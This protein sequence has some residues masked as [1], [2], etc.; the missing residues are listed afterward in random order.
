MTLPRQGC[1]QQPPQAQGSEAS[2]AAPQCHKP[3]PRPRPRPAPHPL[4]DGVLVRRHARPDLGRRDRG[5]IVRVV[6]VLVQVLDGFFRE[7][8]VQVGC[9]FPWGWSWLRGRGQQGSPR[10]RQVI[11]QRCPSLPSFRPPGTVASGSLESKLS[12]DLPGP[13]VAS[14]RIFFLSLWESCRPTPGHPVANQGCSGMAAAC[15]RPPG[16]GHRPLGPHP[17][18]EE[19]R[20]LRTL[21]VRSV[22]SRIQQ[23]MVAVFKLLLGRA[24]CWIPPES[25]NLATT[26]GAGTSV[27]RCK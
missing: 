19:F 2:K 13:L 20:P 7:L 5:V 4:E 15:G 6:V 18:A 22:V 11:G 27:P 8:P 16:P 25:E 23:H 24:P 26:Q 1:S 3:T 21:R 17:P 10:G 12:A 14:S 9:P